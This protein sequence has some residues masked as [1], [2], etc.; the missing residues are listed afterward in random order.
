VASLADAFA[1]V[2]DPRSVRGRWHPLVAILLIAACAVS[3]DADGLTAVWQWVDDADEQVL[4]RLH[5]RACP[6]TGRRRPP[7]ERTIRR[8]LARVDPQ[9]VQQAAGRFV[10]ARLHVAGLAKA[11][12]R[13]REQRRAQRRG[14]H[15]GSGRPGVHFDGKMLRGA[16]R[17]G[18][19]L[20]GLLAGIA[21]G[22]GRVLAQQ[23]IDTKSNEIPALRTL[24][25]GMDLNGYVATGDAA[26][27][28]HATAQAILA[29]GG[30]Y[31]LTLKANQTQLLKAVAPLLSGPDTDWTDRR[32]DSTDRGHGRT[33]TRSVRVAPAT[34]IAFPHAAHVFRT[35][36]YTGGLDGQRTSK[37]VVY[38]ITSLTGAAAEAAEIAVHQRG[39][40]GIENGLHYVRDVTFDEDHSQVRTGHA[41]QN[42]AA[43]RNLAIDT[44][45]TAGHV[46]IAHARRHHTHDYNRILNLYGL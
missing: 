18:G 46:N 14:R 37:Q 1:A 21:H 38:G 29:A 20:L 7:S 13:E 5:V 17:G 10:A 26:H 9:A 16:R 28:Q 8:V 2:P 27:C 35:V 32:H 31:L 12:T 3:C 34:G 11:S 22:S 30:D 39:H 43:L 15:R 25:A 40:W 33:E 24:V 44:F 4:A 45:R 23:A 6:L 42:L 41:P 36:R 19:R